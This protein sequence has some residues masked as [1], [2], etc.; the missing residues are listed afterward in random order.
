MLTTN[1]KKV[2]RLLMASSKIDYSI[3]QIAKRCHLAPN[4]ALKI[5]KKF[6]KEGILKAKKIAN[7]ISYK[8]D[9]SNDKTLNI[10]ELALIPELQG[11]I[12]YRLS[13]FQGLKS[14]TKSCIIF[15]SYANLKKEPDDL[16]VLFIL[17]K[18]NYK[19][20]R[21]KLEDISGI[22]PIKVHDIVQ[23]E[24]DLKENIIKI[25]KVVMEIL[26]NGIVLWGHKTIV[27][28]IQNVNK[29]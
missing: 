20:Y 27:K 15:G 17:D 4:G 2:L 5:L 21:R 7:I 16:D 3:N 22:I 29:G 26:L 11:R 6:E 24:R 8:L 19:E 14:I 12:K 23:T 28:V 10:L 18:E 1:E 13:D 9:L 25:D